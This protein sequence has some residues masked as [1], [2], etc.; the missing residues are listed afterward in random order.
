MTRAVSRVVLLGPSDERIA[1]LETALRVRGHGV[2]VSSDLAH[3]LLLLKVFKPDAVVALRMRETFEIDVLREADPA[4]IV[5]CTD[6]D[7]EAGL[8]LLSRGVSRVLPATADAVALEGVLASG[9]GR[10]R[11]VVRV[12]AQL[13]MFG[14][15][16]SI[17]LSEAADDDNVF[18]T[19]DVADGRIVDARGA[20]VRALLARE[21][22]VR[23]ALARHDDDLDLDIVDDVDGAAVAMSTASRAEAHARLP[24]PRVLLVDADRDV[25]LFA[26]AALSRGGLDVVAVPAFEP[27]VARARS[28][29][30]DVVIVDL[31]PT[32]RGWEFL[33]RLRA[34]AWTREVPVILAGWDHA[35]LA[36][37]RDVGCGAA[38]LLEKSTSPTRWVDTVV[39]VLAP[40]RDL[41][42]DVAAG[43]RRLA[44]PIGGAPG[45]L[46]PVALLRVLARSGFTG[47]MTLT[48]ERGHTDVAL[49]GGDVVAIG[50]RVG[51][52]V[53]DDTAAL[54]QLF[55]FVV[56]SFE[57]HRR[58]DADAPGASRRLDDVLRPAAAEVDLRNESSLA[59][60]IAE[61][62]LRVDP[63]L[64]A[65][66]GELESAHIQ[67]IVDELLAARDVREALARGVDP[68]LLDRTLRDLHARGAVSP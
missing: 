45:A 41:A 5:L 1:A 34:A 15:E 35:L 53:L 12:L 48:D 59:A 63:A 26:S 66:F 21:T 62:R 19:V 36:R 33:G 18:A 60:A 29:L 47:T 4:A 32:A 16:F 46:G 51:G 50:G 13:A 3:G 68:V 58:E 14:G 28:E 52:V 10:E 43:S 22:P 30:P 24:R 64:V 31:G 67:P 17:E 20:D 65:L 49:H 11:P 7:V 27:G 55:H 40:W 61:G 44:G 57:V 9:L 42:V 56:G 8:G 37:L 25:R 39:R 23:A 54:Q 38:A 6:V 2:V